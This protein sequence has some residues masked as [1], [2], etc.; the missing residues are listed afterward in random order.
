MEAC[1]VATMSAGFTG[2]S[3]T[4]MP[5]SR[6]ASSMAAETTDGVTMRPPSPP[7]LMPY[8][9]NGDG[10]STCPIRNGG[11]SLAVGTR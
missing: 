10:V 11:T 4:R 3:R 9:V 2:S 1:T 5:Y 6:R 7:P 8:S